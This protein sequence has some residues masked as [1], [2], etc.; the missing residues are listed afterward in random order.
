MYTMRPP[1]GRYDN[2]IWAMHQR[3][4]EDDEKSAAGDEEED[5]GSSCGRAGGYLPDRHLPLLVE[6]VAHSQSRN[7]DLA[8]FG[9]SADSG[10]GGSYGVKEGDI[11]VAWLDDVFPLSND[12][13]EGEQ[14]KK[15]GKIPPAND[16]DEERGQRTVD[17]P[18]FDGKK[19]AGQQNVT[20]SYWNQNNCSHPTSSAKH[21][22]ECPVVNYLEI[23]VENSAQHSS[24]P[25]AIAVSAV[26]TTIENNDGEGGS[27]EQCRP[28]RKMEIVYGSL[29]EKLRAMIRNR[30]N[31]ARNAGEREGG[32]A[33]GQLWLGIAGPPGSGKTTLAVCAI[34]QQSF[35]QC[36]FSR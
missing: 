35:V 17:D 12:Q 9:A 1:G 22:L 14:I 2:R 30:R 28:D 20:D 32:G 7:D 10:A 3:Y 29:A 31:K 33:E 25:A 18:V 15:N 11:T 16:Q 27:S 34:I 23:S 8:L 24:I 6:I 26:A 13:D 21:S 36:T 19:E 4:L 5:P